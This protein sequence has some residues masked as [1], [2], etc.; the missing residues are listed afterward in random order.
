VQNSLYE[1][2]TRKGGK[3]ESVDLSSRNDGSL[4]RWMSVYACDWLLSDD[5]IEK[6]NDARIAVKLEAIANIIVLRV[7]ENI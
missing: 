2:Y 4:D 7:E 5:W 3:T 6:K 1:V